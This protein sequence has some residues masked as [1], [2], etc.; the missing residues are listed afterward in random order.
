MEAVSEAFRELIKFIITVNLDGFLGG[1]H[2]DV[3]FAAPMQVLIELH[4]QVL[5]DL[6][7]QVIGQLF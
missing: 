7:V 1:I 5:A 2:H 4:F 6:A 3:A